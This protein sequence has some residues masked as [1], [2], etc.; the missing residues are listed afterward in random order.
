M[1]EGL[2]NSVKK[3]IYKDKASSEDMLNY[4]RERGA[5]IGENVKVY[6]PNKTIIDKTVP[7]LLKIG[8][9]VRIT[10]GV[11][12]LTHDYSWSVLKCYS[13][14]VRDSGAVLGAQSPVEI[15]DNVFIG[16][17]TVITRGTKIG[18]NVIIG[19]G[20]VVT[21]EC[22]DNSVYAGNPAKRIMSIEE[23]YSKRQA[24][25]FSEAKQMAIT[26]KERFSVQPPKEVFSEYFMLFSKLDDAVN[27]EKFRRQ[28]E[29]SMNFEKTCEYMNTH[30]PMFDSYEDFLKECYK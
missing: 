20:S 1:I 25:Q 27:C 28:M 4:L 5:Q 15:G 12:I 22:E 6:A 10:E 17:N 8:N 7:W 11:K 2:K 21:R 26:Y 18:S 19:A 16:M 29:T 3:L 9:N 30:P 14:D 23:F 13:S 24:L